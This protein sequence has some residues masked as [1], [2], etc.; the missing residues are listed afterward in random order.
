MEASPHVIQESGAALE[1]ETIEI[2]EKVYLRG[3]TASI[4]PSSWESLR[5][6]QNLANPSGLLLDGVTM[7]VHI[8]QWEAAERVHNAWLRT[9][10]DGVHTYDIYEES[11][12]MGS[13][14][15][16]PEEFGDAL[17]RISHEGVQ[18]QMVDDRGTIVW[19]GGM[20]ETFV[21]DRYRCRFQPVETSARQAVTHA[22][23]S[24]LYEKVTAAGYDIVKTETLRTFD[25]QQGFTL[26]QG[27]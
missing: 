23:I 18:L 6:R 14:G 1:V 19:P 20:A 13:N 9:P 26:A 27:Q 10:E 22:Q 16:N 12:S 15:R 25:G 2:G 17:S 21:T 24:A 3:N 7:P 11:V 5:A 4:D 8:G